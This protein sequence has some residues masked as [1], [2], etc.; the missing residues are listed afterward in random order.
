MM[1]PLAMS[2]PRTFSS[3]APTTGMALPGLANW[4]RIT[5]ISKN[6]NIRNRSDDTPY[7]MPIT[8]WSVLKMYLPKK[9]GS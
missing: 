8:L 2:S 6:P 1:P 9:P 3:K 4:K 7:W 5:S